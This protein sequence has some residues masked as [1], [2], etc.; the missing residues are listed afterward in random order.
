MKRTYIIRSGD[1]PPRRVTFGGR[2]AWF[3]DELIE[4]G[5]SGRTSLDHPGVR[6]S[7]CVLKLR[8]G[9]VLIETHDEEHGGRFAGRH[10]RYTLASKIERAA[11]DGNPSH[12][13]S[14]Q[15][16]VSP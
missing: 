4:A 2:V 14:V 16:T 13:P 9:G 3:L 8:R 15:A 5:A 12:S 7:D 10:G 1:Q 6:L 11:S